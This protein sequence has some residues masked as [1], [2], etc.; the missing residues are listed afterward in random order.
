[1]AC[2]I[3]SDP[4]S[5][6]PCV[7]LPLCVK[8]KN[9][10]GSLRT[11]WSE[12][13]ARCFDPSRSVLILR[14]LEDRL[15][16]FGWSR[17]WG[18]RFGPHISEFYLTFFESQQQPDCICSVDANEGKRAFVFQPVRW[19]KVCSCHNGNPTPH[20]DALL[21]FWKWKTR[22]AQSSGWSR[23]LSFPLRSWLCKARRLSS[24]PGQRR[25]QGSSRLGAFLRL[26]IRNH[27]VN[28]SVLLF[29]LMRNPFSPD[30]L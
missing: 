7:F 12:I 4:P 9:I 6:T 18:W 15:R 2:L 3:R 13:S 1:M 20:A 14:S 28:G 16:F 23:P 30:I 8:A 22:R 21:F 26:R 19:A 27:F 29:D 17:G 11:S 5:H 25:S 24:L 10:M